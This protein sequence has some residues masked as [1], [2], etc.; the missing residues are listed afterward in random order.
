MFKSYAKYAVLNDTKTY[1]E[2][3]DTEW[4]HTAPIRSIHH[5]LLFNMV[6]NIIK[7]YSAIDLNIASNLALAI[8]WYNKK[9][10]LDITR[11]IVLPVYEQYRTDVEKYL[12]LI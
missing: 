6:E 11:K 5:S 8:R 3:I 9:Y 7:V 4:R 1:Y 10:S 2:I 12:M